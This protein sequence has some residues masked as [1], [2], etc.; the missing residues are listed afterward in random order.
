MRREMDLS[1]I[2]DGRLY[3]SGDMVKTDCRGCVGCSACCRG[4][5]TSI[6]L[7]PMDIWRM[8]T[9]LEKRPEELFASSLELNVADGLI[10]PNLK[11]D[12]QGES[13]IFLNQEGRCG[14]HEA[15]PGICRLFPLGRFYENRSFRYFLQVH[16]CPENKS[17][18]KVEKW[19]GIPNIRRYEAYIND[20][21]FFL[22]DVE[23]A[24]EGYGEEERRQMSLYLLR[25][26]YLLPYPKEEFYG[27]F[28]KRLNRARDQFL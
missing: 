14:I 20:W 15:R 8:T 5:G 19:L 24:L 26:F 7:D 28:E 9:A 6:V 25:Q 23:E 22:R 12:G 4:M 10:L 16:E 3:D 11:M 18:I 1:E 21:H 2:S 17:K 27:E 13:C